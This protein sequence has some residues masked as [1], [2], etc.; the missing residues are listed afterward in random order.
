MLS[1]GK[2]PHE[3]AHPH[4]SLSEL[5]W[6]EDAQNLSYPTLR[7]ADTAHLAESILP[8]LCYFCSA[9]GDL[10][11][12]KLE[13]KE[14]LCSELQEKVFFHAKGGQISFLKNGAEGQPEESTCVH[15]LIW[16]LNL[17][18][19]K[20]PGHARGTWHNFCSV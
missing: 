4:V 2:H 7:S 16:S 19:T 5:K 17:Q 14:F 1:L 11:N 9:V 13:P 18:K 6:D 20:E 10:S 12:K 3:P 8:A 15:C